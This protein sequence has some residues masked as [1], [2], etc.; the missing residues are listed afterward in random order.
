MPSRSIRSARTLAASASAA[1]RFH[2]SADND[3]GRGNLA[4]A[5]FFGNVWIR[6]DRVIDGGQ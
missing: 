1:G 6:R 5:D 2:D 3:S 4:A